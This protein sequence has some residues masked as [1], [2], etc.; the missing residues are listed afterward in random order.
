MPGDEWQRFANLRMLYAYMFTHPGTRLLFM[1]GEFG[2]TSEWNIEKGLEWWLT[3]QRY[4]KGVQDLV[5]DLNT[6]YREQGALYHKQFS[7]DGFEWIDQSDA[8]NSVLSYLRKGHQEDPEVLVICNFTPVVRENYKIGVSQAGE[9]TEVL[10][11]DD[12]KYGGSGVV[13]KETLQTIDLNWHGRYQALNLT[14]APLSV[15]VLQFV[16]KEEKKTKAKAK[17]KK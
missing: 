8:K 15:K 10:S 2:Q 1:G 14:L 12:L 3:G 6:L 5:R 16:P 9:W 4:H 13:E 7:P 11:T 17:K